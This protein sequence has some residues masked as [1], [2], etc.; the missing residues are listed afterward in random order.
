FFGLRGAT[1]RAAIPR[2][3]PTLGSIQVRESTG[4]SVYQSMTIRANFRRKIAQFNA[5]YTL[6]RSLS[7]DD[8][9]R[10][11]G[12]IAYENAYNL[13]PEF[14]FSRLDR[15]HQFVANTVVYLPLGIEASSALRLRSGLPIDASVGSDFN[16]DIGGPDRPYSA[17][18][19]P[20]KRN[21]FRNLATYEI[22]FRVQKGISLGDQRRLIFSAEFFNLLNAE[23]IQLSGA[24]VTNYCASP[25]G[26]DCGF[27]APTNRNFLRVKDVNGNYLLNNN[28]GAP[29][30]VQL[31]ARL[32]F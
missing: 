20:F 29:F 21:A 26:R 10:D 1:G 8:N 16:E 22:D 4:R 18:G 28:P 13:A 11:A 31:G 9:E 24:Q 6:S 3:I 32:Q 25:V 7:N 19:V 12:G 27:S 30:Q 14:S 23:N 2:P 17:A 5:F 15:R